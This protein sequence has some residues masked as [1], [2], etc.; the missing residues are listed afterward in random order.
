MCLSSSSLSSLIVDFPRYPRQAATAASKK[1]TVRFAEHGQLWMIKP[2][3]DFIDDP[4]QL[5]YSSNDDELSSLSQQAFESKRALAATDLKEDIITEDKICLCAGLELESVITRTNTRR[6]RNHRRQHMDTIV[7]RQDMCSPE[8]LSLMSMQSSRL[9]R[10]RAHKLAVIYFKTSLSAVRL[11]T[12]D[13][14]SI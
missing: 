1:K 8:T 3:F 4:S 9:A 7:S 14:P 2:Y 5:W 11:C 10:K 13:A 6:V 12:S